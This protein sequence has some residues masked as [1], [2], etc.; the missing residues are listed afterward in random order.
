L[1]IQSRLD[2]HVTHNTANY[3]TLLQSE[4]KKI[5]GKNCKKLRAWLNHCGYLRMIPE[6]IVLWW[7]N[8]VIQLATVMWTTIHNPQELQRKKVTHA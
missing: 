2:L 7:R 1:I 3:Y 6:R 4:G 8:L 5:V